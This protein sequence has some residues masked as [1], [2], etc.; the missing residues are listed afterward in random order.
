MLA[1][2]YQRDAVQTSLVADVASAYIELKNLD[3]RL[4]ISRR[5]VDSRRE[6]LDLVKARGEGGVGAD[7]ETG[8]AEALL[9]QALT[10]IPITEKAIAEKENQIRSL[11]GE[12]P[13]GI[14]RGDTLDSLDQSL[15]IK[16]G[17]PSSLLERRPDVAAANQS[18]QAAVAQI[19][20]A[21]AMRLPSLSL[22]GNGGVVSGD[23]G[24]LMESKS[25]AYSIGP[26][27]AG[28][29]FDAGRG[30]ARA[31]AARARAGEALAIYNKTSQQAFREAADAINAH[32]KTGEI[33][34]RQN[35]LV[36]SYRKVARVATDR[37]QGG[38]SGYLEVLDAERSLFN[39]ELEQADARRNRLLSVVYAYRALGG[40]WQ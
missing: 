28:P 5:T 32:V 25:A 22:T 2:Y 20:V 9:G 15:R 24:K 36:E 7:L 34:A 13:G 35:N 17:L 26:N 38:A 19:G 12:Y 8:Q 30:K 33:A 14:T 27:L 3:E 11:L 16:G 21:E 1:A 4:A 29:I 37:F 18:F 10:A 31:E 23:L 6:S 39:A 40:G